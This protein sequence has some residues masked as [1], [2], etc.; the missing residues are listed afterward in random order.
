MHISI[1]LFSAFLTL[2]FNDVKFEWEHI[3]YYD[4]NNRECRHTNNQNTANID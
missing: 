3:N 2:C 4:I 1:S